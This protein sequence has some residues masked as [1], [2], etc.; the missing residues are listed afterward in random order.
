MAMAIVAATAGLTMIMMTMGVRPSFFHAV[1]SAEGLLGGDVVGDGVGGE[2]DVG[3][4]IVSSRPLS[5]GESPLMRS[6]S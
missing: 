2:S 6:G 4:G 3:A 5:V 1:A